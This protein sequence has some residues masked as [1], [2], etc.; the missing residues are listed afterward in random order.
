MQSCAIINVFVEG[1]DQ[2]FCVS[3]AANYHATCREF[4]LAAI[5][6]FNT[7]ARQCIFNS[8]RIVQRVL[9]SLLSQTSALLET[10]LYFRRLSFYKANSINELLA[11][12]LNNWSV[13]QQLTTRFYLVDEMLVTE[14]T[15]RLVLVELK[16]AGRIYNCHVV[17]SA[18]DNFSVTWWPKLAVFVA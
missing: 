10:S 12:C 4:W 15:S 11:A 8:A 2:Q 13:K 5:K 3:I 6:T 14:S 16:V 7:V 17:F 9:R 1:L 18:P